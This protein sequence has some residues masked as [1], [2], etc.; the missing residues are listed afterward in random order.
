MVFAGFKELCGM[1]SHILRNMDSK[2][3][4]SQD[5]WLKMINGYKALFKEQ[6]T[7]TALIEGSQALW[8]RHYWPVRRQANLRKILQ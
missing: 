4:Y 5:K 7:N 8:R 6:Y 3:N 1:T 2:N